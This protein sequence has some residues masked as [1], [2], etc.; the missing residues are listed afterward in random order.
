M[1]RLGLGIAGALLAM[2]CG[3]GGGYVMHLDSASLP[4]VDCNSNE[5]DSGAGLPDPYVVLVK[6]WDVEDVWRSL[7]VDD[8]TEPLYDAPAFG[9]EALSASDLMEFGLRITVWDEDG[10]VAG[11]EQVAEQIHRF[12]Q[13]QLDAGAVTVAVQCVD[14]Q[15]SLH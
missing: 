10:A 8:E 14:V 9:S 2:G 13:D 5:Y 4:P 11:P 6:N 15:L 1:A 12:S 3:K 7:H